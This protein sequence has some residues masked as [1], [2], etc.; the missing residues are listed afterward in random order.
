VEI[1]GLISCKTAVVIG[2]GVC[3]YLYAY[4]LYGKLS[5]A[6]GGLYGDW[7]PGTGVTQIFVVG[8]VRISGYTGASSIWVVI[9]RQ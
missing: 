6:S 1:L 8:T 7:A 2:K 5:G 9:L 3:P 4:A